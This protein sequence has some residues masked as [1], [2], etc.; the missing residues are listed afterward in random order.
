M[1]LSGLQR[2][3]CAAKSLRGPHISQQYL[4]G[5]RY[6]LCRAG[7]LVWALCGRAG[8][9]S[10]HFVSPVPLCSFTL[11]LPSRRCSPLHLAAHKFAGRTQGPDSSQETGSGRLSEQEVQQPGPPAQASAEQPAAPQQE[12]PRDLFVPILVVVSLLAYCATAGI[13]WLQYNTDLLDGLS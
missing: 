11:A 8:W 2:R 6:Q 3:L 7:K 1:Q 12:E 5:S 13:A 9:A 4:R 10:T